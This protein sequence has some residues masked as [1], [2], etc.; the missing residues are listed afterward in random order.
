MLF[1]IGFE[2]RKRSFTVNFLS[3]RLPQGAFTL[4]KQVEWEQVCN[5]TLN[6]SYYVMPICFLH[7]HVLETVFT[8]PQFWHFPILLWVGTEVPC[9][10]L[11]FS[12]L[13]FVYV[14]DLGYCFMLFFKG[15][16]GWVHFCICLFKI[17]DLNVNL[18][19]VKFENLTFCTW[20]ISSCFRFWLRVI[21]LS[22]CSSKRSKELTFSPLLKLDSLIFTW[23]LRILDLKT[24]FSHVFMMTKRQSEGLTFLSKP[25]HRAF[26]W[27]PHSEHSI[28]SGQGLC[29]ISFEWSQQGLKLKL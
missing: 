22:D 29:C 9:I 7:A 23:V 2:Y 5:G 15:S 21:F 16:S 24:N 14:F 28:H 8:D 4:N 26:C 11:I 12:H 13:D 1:S 17:L 18:L 3:W 6:M 19:R 27:I 10:Y 20:L 25:I